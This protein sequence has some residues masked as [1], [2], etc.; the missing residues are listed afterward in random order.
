MAIADDGPHP[1]ARSFFLGTLAAPK[2][3]FRDSQ[4]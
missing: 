4:N 3:P 1:T 2:G